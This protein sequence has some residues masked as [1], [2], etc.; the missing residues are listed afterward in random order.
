MVATNDDSKCDIQTLHVVSFN[1]HGFNQGF[2]T[3]RDLIESDAP[4]VFLLEEHWLTPANLH[5]FNDVFDRYFTFGSSAMSSAVQS[6]IIRGRP[7]GGMMT[8]INNNL[9]NATTTVFCNDRCVVIKI[10][11]WIIIGIYLPCVGTDNRLLICQDVLMEAWTWRERFPDCKCLIGG[12]FNC[13][14]DNSQPITDFINVFMSEQGLIRCDSSKVGPKAHTYVNESLGHCSTIDFFVTSDIMASHDFRIVDCD[15][16]LSDHLPISITLDCVSSGNKA[17]QDSKENANYVT[18]LRWDHA[19]ILSYYNYTGQH[20]QTI[21]DEIDSFSANNE[22]VDMQLFVDI[23][24]SKIV[25]VLRD[26]ATLYVPAKKKSFYKFWWDE[27]L[28][29][30]KQESINSAKLWKASGKPRSGNIFKNYQ[31]ARSAYRKSLREHQRMEDSSYTNNLHEALAEKNGKDFWKCWR[32]KFEHSAKYDQIDGCTD[33]QEIAEHFAQ[34]FS[35]ACSSANAERAAELKCEYNEKRSRY[36]GLPLLNENKID[37]ELI[38]EIINN[39]QRGKAAGLDSLTAEHLHFSHSILFNILAKLFNIM[40][41][42]G[43][44]PLGFGCSYTVPLIKTDCHSKAL[45]TNDFRG[46]SISP[47]ISKVFEHFCM[48]RR[49]KHFLAHATTSLAL[50]LDSGARMQLILHVVLLI[51]TLKVAQ[52]LIFVR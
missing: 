6:D 25:N 40:L 12:D 21:Y 43:C 17:A 33:R 3:V 45:S 11:N 41:T 18:Q 49:Y 24:Y 27:E 26:A 52:P 9:R 32:A 20:L 8:L 28:N 10:Y 19:D 37:V 29:I 50:K 42:A 46:I 1:M 48:F 38:D 16:N 31:T 5:T 15:A 4:R 13:D 34:H 2:P 47:V 44:I 30:L 39:L 36:C 14:L 7:F 22:V 35:A 51:A 23:M